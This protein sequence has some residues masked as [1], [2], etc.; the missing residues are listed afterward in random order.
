VTSRTARVLFL[1]T[2]NYYRSRFAEELWRHLEGEHPTGATA[3]SR[4]LLVSSVLGNVGCMSV[5]ALEGLAIQ[6]VRVTLPQRSPRQVE[7]SDFAASTHVVAVCGREHRP[8]LHRLFPAW[9]HAVEYWDVEDVDMCAVDAALEKLTVHVKA[10][11]LRL[12]SPAGEGRAH[13]NGLGVPID[14]IAALQQT[15]SKLDDDL[16]A[17]IVA[18]GPAIIPELI[19][20]L[21]DDDLA[22]EDTDGQGWPPIHA[23]DL[24]VHLKATEAIEPLLAILAQTEFVQII[25]DRILQYLPE[26]GEAVLEPALTLLEGLSDPRRRHDA[27]SA[28]D[29]AFGSLCSVLSQ[30]KVR[31]D[32]VYDLLC[33]EFERNPVAG[34]IDFGEYGDPRALPLLAAKMG[35]LAADP[36]GPSDCALVEDLAEAYVMIAGALPRE[37]VAHVEAVHAHRAARVRGVP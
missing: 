33:D 34:A 1:C 31:D 36:V 11:H 16:R 35:T 10:L 28:D 5:H 23:V 30:L 27:A 25:H 15:G 8:M 13:D 37:L 21:C 29:D 4:G 6:G 3:Q 19:E 26:L 18:L 2:G 32:R 24:L 9:A 20:V 7:P 22:R 17:R 12:R 14:P